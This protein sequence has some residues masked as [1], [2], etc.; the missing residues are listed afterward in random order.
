V[1]PAP[2]SN[3]LPLPFRFART[4]CARR[5]SARSV[6]REPGGEEHGLDRD[7]ASPR[8]DHTENR[9]A[10]SAACTDQAPHNVSLA[11]SAADYNNAGGSRMPS[12]RTALLIA[13]A[14]A[15]VLF[16]LCTPALDGQGLNYDE[17][18]AAP[19]TFLLLGKPAYTFVMLAWRRFPLLTM[20]YIG[21]VKSYLFALWM[22]TSGV[23]FSVVSWRL[24]GIAFAAIGLWAF[25]F[26][27]ATALSPLALVAFL[28][29]FLSDVTLLLLVRHDAGPVD[30]ALMLR[31]VWLGVW[32]RS[33]VLE[34]PG[35]T[36][37]LLL[38][39]IPSFLVYE[40][41]NNV[42][43]VGALAVM[44]LLTGRQV[45]R[46]RTLTIAIGFLLGLLP[47]ALVN[48]LGHGISF[49]A[50]VQQQN[51]ANVA[52]LVLGVMTLGD[53]NEVRTFILGT[54]SAAWIRQA[55]LGFAVASATFVIIV[56]WA[57]ARRDRD[58]RL[59]AGSLAAYAMTIVMIA[60]LI[61]RISFPWHWFV[62]TPLQYL[63]V[64][65]A[66]QALTRRATSTTVPLLV[67]AVFGIF[68]AIRIGNVVV[69][70]RELAARRSSQRFDP[71]NT[72]VAQYAVDHRN[73]ATT[74][75]ADWG[76]GVQIYALS[77]GTLAVPELFWSWGSEW[78]IDRLERYVAAR[79]LPVLV[80]LRKGPAAVSDAVTADIVSSVE[81]ITRGRR[82]PVDPAL[83]GSPILRVLKFAPPAASEPPL[84]TSAPDAPTG[85]RV[86]INS[87]GFVAL[88]WDSPATMPERY[89]LEVRQAPSAEA[90]VIELG[91]WPRF[92]KA[93]VA[94]GTYSVR[95]R[96]R[97]RCGVSPSSGELLVVVP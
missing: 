93:A 83:D 10:G 24:S 57:W 17:A 70:E 56:A 95:V 27:G 67:I 53:G 60:I 35:R 8:R 52:A 84:C 34:R 26:L 19:A 44:T 30:A 96:A 91:H 4:A 59:A 43:L 50:A 61:P 20:T 81:A 64:A 82:L 58:A 88:A 73:D 86:A 5:L 32:L 72:A 97:N 21:A 69:L 63:A 90:T 54:D 74:V 29:L 40:K 94:R 71:S 3:A 18:H 6:E 77:N 80:L 33:E 13:T 45:R 2:C 22:W 42:V 23:P 48:W 41:L 51:A 15:A 66:M 37:W 31:L 85:L 49:R 7:E 12:R 89:S 68:L 55:E 11:P 38:G 47:F 46:T 25:C 39:A 65:L 87:G 76:F 16:L 1:P 14:G 79:H 9:C 62:A 92:A 28:L 75:A 78:D 36:T